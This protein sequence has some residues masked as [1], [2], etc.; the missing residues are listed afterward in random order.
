MKHGLLIITDIFIQTAGSE[1]NITQLL[2]GLDSTR[3]NLHLAVLESG[4]L[5]HH[6]RAEGH[7]V[8]LLHNAP[9]YSKK[10]FQNTLFLARLIKERHISLILTYHE[11]SDF[12]G[13]LLSQLRRVPVV[14]C[15]RDMG[16]LAKRRHRIAY[17]LFG[18][19]FSAIIAVSDAVKHSA[20]KSGWFPANRVITI[21]NGVDLAPFDASLPRGDGR[22]DLGIDASSSVLGVISALRQVKGVGYLIEALPI[23]HRYH[24]NV[25]CVVVGNDAAEPG[26]MSNLRGLAQQLNVHKHVHFLGERRDIPRLIPAFSIGV[27]PSLSEGFSNVILEYM[28]SSKPVVATEVGGNSEAV[29]NG[30]TGFLVPPADPRRLGDVIVRLLNDKQMMARFGRAGRIRVEQQFSLRSMLHK[31]EDVFQRVIFNG[32]KLPTSH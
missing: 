12:Y 11:S 25:H 3:Y 22:S 10:G 9:F 19:L 7:S 23:I 6:M 2:A 24:P 8:Y 14:S 27:V 20:T 32:S 29:V 13:L 17:R 1:R 15:R 28:A 30:V 26:L 5:A 31:Y 18:R 21:H 16:F 4:P